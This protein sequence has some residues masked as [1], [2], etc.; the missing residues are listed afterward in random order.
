MEVLIILFGAA[1]LAVAAV[2]LGLF[3]AAIRR[4]IWRCPRGHVERSVG[5]V[6]VFGAW[7]CG[8]FTVGVLW[9]WTYSSG[10]ASRHNVSPF[11]S[12][13]L[14]AAVGG[15]VMAGIMGRRFVPLPVP[16]PAV[17][18][19]WYTDMNG[20]TRWWSGEAWTE[21]TDG[22]SPPATFS[23]AWARSESRPLVAPEQPVSRRNSPPPPPPS[24]LNP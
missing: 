1:S 4:L 21:Y 13:V 3:A 5:A 11:A 24:V 16:V 19:G 14:A 12:V 18:P 9:L 10:L 15:L 7:I 6:R 17:Q 2:P 8:L 23:E 20:V 22:A